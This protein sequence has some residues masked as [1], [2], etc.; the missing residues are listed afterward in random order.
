MSRPPDNGLGEFG[1]PHSPDRSHQ[2]LAFPQ[3]LTS[4][5]VDSRLSTGPA[6]PAFGSV[7]YPATSTTPAPAS[8]IARH[9][10][11]FAT[12]AVLPAPRGSVQSYPSSFA[13]PPARSLRTGGH[14]W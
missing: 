3:I 8:Q 7:G 11:A 4:S 12:L 5:Q 9:C 1:H 10:R 14:C 2:R 6:G 13:L